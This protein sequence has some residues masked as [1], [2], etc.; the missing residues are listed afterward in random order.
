MSWVIWKRGPGKNTKTHSGQNLTTVVHGGSLPLV[1]K[2]DTLMFT[3]RACIA[4][5][6]AAALAPLVA[7]NARDIAG[8]AN[9]EFDPSSPLPH[10]TAFSPFAG[11]YMNS[12]SQ[13]PLSLGARDA[14]NRYMD[15]KTFANGNDHSVLRPTSATSKTTHDSSMPARKKSASCRA[16]PLVKTSY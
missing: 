4:G 15:F 3:R 2:R 1:R 16:R 14:I 6:S 13:H 9:H 8:D 5:A 11:S 7:G 12:A 10:K